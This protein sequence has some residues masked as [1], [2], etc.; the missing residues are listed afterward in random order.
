VR[1]FLVIYYLLPNFLKKKIP[2]QIILIN[3]QAILE[4]LSI[5]A[6]IP[7]AT[8]LIDGENNKYSVFYQNNLREYFFDIE[9]I[10]FCFFIFL[11]IIILKNL[12]ISFTIKTQSKFIFSIERYFSNLI[13][14]NIGNKNYDFFVSNNSSSFIKIMIQEA[15]LANEHTK[16]LLTIISEILIIFFIFF[17]MIFINYKLLLL[18]IITSFICFFLYNLFYKKK[19]NTI[20]SKFLKAERDRVQTLTEFYEMI[21]EILIYGKKEIFNQRWK[22]IL[23]V[24][25]DARIFRAYISTYFRLWIETFGFA[26]IAVIVL[27][28]Y[29]S[30]SEFLSY[31]PLI[32]F[33]VLSFIRLIPSLNRIVSSYQMIKL[34]SK[35]ID[36]FVNYINKSNIGNQK[37]TNEIIF[38]KK[39][40]L[41]KIFYAY[42]NSKKYILNN[43]SIDIEK[44][45]LSLVCGGN[46]SGKTTLMNLFLSLLELQKG[47]IFIDEKKVDHY[48][49]KEF[50]YKNVGYIP[51]NP[52]L[53]EGT[54][55]ENITLEKNNNEKDI[56]KVNKI[57]DNLNLRNFFNNFPV[58]FNSEIKESGKNLSGGQIQIVCILRALFRDPKILIFDE[59]TSAMDFNNKSNFKNLLSTLLGNYS[60]LVIS[61][62]RIEDIKFD[63]VINLNEI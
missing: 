4:T 31:L 15:A 24:S 49:Y 42:P 2:I 32:S 52:K 56:I 18:I 35:S 30:N 48:S 36:F 9:F 12:V 37:K 44:N 50:I 55:L 6:I 60:I 46:G 59:P 34:H 22:E 14:N 23:D 1:K 7:L 26:L 39:I 54:L 58:N 5:A 40:S 25:L 47:E 43:F 10:P 29:S 21:K 19:I 11:L 45:T 41:N 53:F 57:I 28:S 38:N 17:G 62:D 8:F 13:F 63:Q 27:F 51:Q 33:F 3:L 16:F 20:S 61:H